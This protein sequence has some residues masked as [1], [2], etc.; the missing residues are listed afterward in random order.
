MTA[1]LTNVLT[2][3]FVRIRPSILRNNTV[4]ALFISANMRNNYISYK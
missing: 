1:V 3:N 4:A 2:D